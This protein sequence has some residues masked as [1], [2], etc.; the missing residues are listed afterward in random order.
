VGQ[1]LV[2]EERLFGTTNDEP[3]RRLRYLWLPERY[4]DREVGDHE[5]AVVWLGD[6]I[7]LA[8]R[9]GDPEGLV[10]PQLSHARRRSVAALGREPDELEQR[11][12]Q[13]VEQ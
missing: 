10:V 8:I 13:F 5:L 2:R 12:D 6:G 3:D 7:E 9:T 1:R 11:A 4:A